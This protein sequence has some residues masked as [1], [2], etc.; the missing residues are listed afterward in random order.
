MQ[1]THGGSS[2]I[3]HRCKSFP[4]SFNQPAAIG[5][6]TEFLSFF[7]QSRVFYHLY[8]D[9]N[10]F[11]VHKYFEIFHSQELTYMS[12]LNPST[13]HKCLSDTYHTRAMAD[14][15]FYCL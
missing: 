12:A 9:T 6:L 15:G 8:N 10:S 11:K 7:K 3:G 13:V 2:L 1:S 4:K 5:I 14:R